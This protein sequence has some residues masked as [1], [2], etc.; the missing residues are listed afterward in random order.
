M[1][2]LRDYVASELARKVSQKG[3]V[4]WQD[5]E[6]EYSDVAASLCLWGS[7]TRSV[8]PEPRQRGGIR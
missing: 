1:K 6:C 4:V 8:G 2:E 5:T 7:K 3:V